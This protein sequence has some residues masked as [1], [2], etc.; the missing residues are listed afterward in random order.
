MELVDAINILEEVKVLDDSMYKYNDAYME[1]L[2]YVLDIVK[3][4]SREQIRTIRERRELE[5][6]SLKMP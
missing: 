4:L 5:R 6:L 2:D 1:A 3:G